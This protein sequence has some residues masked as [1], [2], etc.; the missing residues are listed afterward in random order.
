MRPDT[1]RQQ[2]ADACRAYIAELGEDVDEMILAGR[3]DMVTKAL[4]IR[5]ITAAVEAVGIHDVANQTTFAEGFMEQ[6]NAK[7]EALR[8]RLP[9]AST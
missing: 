2:A 8:G 9:I 3:G 7:I 1:L 4:A 6:A 5:A